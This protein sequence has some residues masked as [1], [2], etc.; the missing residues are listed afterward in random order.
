MLRIRVFFLLFFYIFI[1]YCQQVRN[2]NLK[3]K[4]KM[5]YTMSQ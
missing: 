5:D 2:G 3:F 1:S 4:L